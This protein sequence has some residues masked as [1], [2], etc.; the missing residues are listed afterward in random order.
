MAA[1]GSSDG[2]MLP[3]ARPLPTP[4][5]SCDTPFFL[6]TVVSS[7]SIGPCCEAASFRDSGAECGEDGAAET[8]VCLS[9]FVL[10]HIEALPYVCV[11]ALSA[12]GLLLLAGR[13]AA[14]RLSWPVQSEMRTQVPA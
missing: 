5:T 11:A 6:A 7:F 8:C 3:S 9:G 14:T 12:E 2:R 1:S 10:A 4:T 13:L